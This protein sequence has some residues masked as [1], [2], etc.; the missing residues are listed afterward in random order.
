[1]DNTSF[2]TEENVRF[3]VDN[4]GDGVWLSLQGRQASMH[5]TLTREEAKQLLSGLQTI[6]N[7][8]MKAA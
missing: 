4:W 2:M 7:Q 3:S 8:T 1:M 6:L 5:S